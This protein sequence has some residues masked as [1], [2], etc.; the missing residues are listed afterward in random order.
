M[1]LAD[2]IIKDETIAIKGGNNDDIRKKEGI[3]SSKQTRIKL[4]TKVVVIMI[5]F[6]QS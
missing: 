6:L 4:E 5:V 1:Q 3:T 2:H